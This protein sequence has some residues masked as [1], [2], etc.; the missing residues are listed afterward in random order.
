M[1][2][3]S[4]ISSFNEIKEERERRKRNKENRRKHKRA[5]ARRAEWKAAHPKGEPQA[6]P[7]SAMDVVKAV[8]AKRKAA[9]R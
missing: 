9:K 8:S 6:Q 2:K 5:K 3:I 4:D 7:Q 1:Y